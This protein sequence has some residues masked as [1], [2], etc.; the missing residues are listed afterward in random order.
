MA[1]MAFPWE[2]QKLEG[3]SG[4]VRPIF[5]LDGEKQLFVISSW[6]LTMQDPELGLKKVMLSS[7][8]ASAQK[9]VLPQPLFSQSFILGQFES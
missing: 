4:R 9:S 6:I 8:V 7:P 3:C 5:T 2:L 1:D